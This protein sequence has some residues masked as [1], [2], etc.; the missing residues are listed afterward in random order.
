MAYN[1]TNFKNKIKEIEEWLKRE[2]ST[3][4][5]GRAMPTVL[6]AVKVESYGAFVGVNELANVT[7]EDAR[8]IRIT[9]W[10]L[11]QSKAIEKAIT[12]LNLGVSVTVDDK[13]LRVIFPEL[14]TE[15]RT[16]V[17]KT[18]KVKLEE[19]KIKVRKMRDDVMK[20]LQVLEKS[21]GTG[22][23][24]INRFKNDLQKMVDE[25]NKKLEESFTKKEKEIIS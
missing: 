1:F 6:D 18:A 17:V 7:L 16:E 10:D 12:T 25:V 23:D 14:T 9:P 11:S 3:I 22:K 2:F 5:T 19:S 15:R 24:D 4:R 21:G 13:G 20:E 8:C